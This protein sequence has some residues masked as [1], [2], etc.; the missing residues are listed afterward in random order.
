MAVRAGI[1]TK[2]FEALLE[3]LAQM[4]ADVDAATDTALREGGQTLLDGMLRRV[5]R[6]TGNLAA[7]LSI[8]GPHLDGNYHYITVGLNHGVDADTAR[9][10]TVQE[11][12]AADTPA[13]PYIRPTLE[14]DMRK[15]RQAMVRI[16]QELL[17]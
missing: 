11:Y 4:G 13:Q 7:N 16:F 9:Y 12:G 1:T 17:Q 10:G 2:G 5:P 14:E 6:D 8:D 15:A 3:A